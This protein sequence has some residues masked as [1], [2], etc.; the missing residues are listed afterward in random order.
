MGIPTPSGYGYPSRL[1]AIVQVTIIRPTKPLAPSNL[2]LIRSFSLFSVVSRT[3][4]PTDRIL[5]ARLSRSLR[6][7]CPTAVLVSEPIY[8]SRNLLRMS[9]WSWRRCPPFL[10]AYPLRPLLGIRAIRVP[11]AYDGSPRLCVDC[12]RTPHGVRCFVRWLALLL[13]PFGV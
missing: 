4:T 10:L 5:L 13:E 11:S 3:V 8:A 1:A 2:G 7:P 6:A 9:E 12:V